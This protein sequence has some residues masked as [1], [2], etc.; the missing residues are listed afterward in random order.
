MV[1]SDKCRLAKGDLCRCSC[2]GTNHGIGVVE[3]KEE[4]E[5]SGGEIIFS[6]VDPQKSILEFNIKEVENNGS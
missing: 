2:D 1:C 6:F 4:K 3:V 5:E